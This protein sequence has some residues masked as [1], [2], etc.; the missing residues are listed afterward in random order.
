MGRSYLIDQRIDG[1]GGVGGRAGLDFA[2]KLNYMTIMQIFLLILTHLRAAI[3]VR[4]A[5]ERA[6][7]PL[8]VLVWGR[9]ARMAQRMERLFA[10]WKAGTLPPPRPS[11]AGRTRKA[12]AATGYPTG[13]NWLVGHAQEVVAFGSQIAHVLHDPEFAAF[14]AAVPQAGRILRPLLRMLAVNPLPATVRTAKAMP[15]PEA[16]STPILPGWVPAVGPIFSRA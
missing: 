12:C 16:L 8:F 6:L 15:A 10:R 2:P 14:V 5:R 3:A 7:S 13:A 4:A 1:D 11:Q 9:V